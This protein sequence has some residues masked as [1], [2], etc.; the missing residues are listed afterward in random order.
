MKMLYK[1]MNATFAYL[2]TKPF[3]TNRLT[4]QEMEQLSKYTLVLMQQVL[5]R[6][7]RGDTDC[8]FIFADSKL[9]LHREE[10]KG[11]KRYSMIANWTDILKQYESHRIVADLFF[12]F[13]VGLRYIS[14]YE[15]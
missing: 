12:P 6:M 9:D 2:Q 7:V 15:I 3:M 5:G 8:R 1:E 14:E 10:Q 4:E 11:N 13:A